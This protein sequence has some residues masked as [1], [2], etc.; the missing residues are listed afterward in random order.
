MGNAS[1]VDR[2]RA[3]VATFGGKGLSG[4]LRLQLNRSLEAVQWTMSEM[5]VPVE[6]IEEVCGKLPEAPTFAYRVNEQWLHLLERHAQGERACG[7][8]WTGGHWDPTAVCSAASRN[9]ACTECETL[10]KD[11]G[12][13]PETFNSGRDHAGSYAYRWFN[14][15]ACELGDLSGMWGELEAVFNESEQPGSVTIPSLDLPGG[16]AQMSAMFASISYESLH[17]HHT[18]ILCDAT[19]PPSVHGK[20]C[21]CVAYNQK[22]SPSGGAMTGFHPPGNVAFYHAGGASLSKLDGKSIVVQCGS[23]FGETAGKPLFCA[24]LLE[25]T[26]QRRHLV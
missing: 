22:C 12:C 3:L 9:K 14:E 17:D 7:E 5:T 18:G 10:G 24:A 1:E 20:H 11:Y 15:H 26:A 19:G 16:R 21:E 6:L 2:A 8:F 25:D 13:S 4:S 23:N